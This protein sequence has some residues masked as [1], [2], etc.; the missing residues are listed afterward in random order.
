[1]KPT[2]TLVHDM[3]YAY[4]MLAIACI[5]VVYNPQD[6]KALAGYLD[7]NTTL[8][9]QQGELDHDAITSCDEFARLSQVNQE[10]Y[11]RI[12]EMKLREATGEDAKYIDDRVYQRFLAKKALQERFFPANPLTETKHGYDTKQE[13]KRV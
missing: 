12:N 9:Q 5:K 13:D 4:D 8:E 10:M 6:H 3:A 2:V 1:M 11:I 7:L